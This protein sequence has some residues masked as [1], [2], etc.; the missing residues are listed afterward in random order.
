ME[1]QQANEK[2]GLNIPESD[3]YET[4]AGFILHHHQ[5]FPKLNEII[6]IGD[7]NLRCIKVTNNRI[8]LIRL[9]LGG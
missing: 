7:F 2:F 6:H 4:I 1:V 3:E 8:E 5:H 9:F